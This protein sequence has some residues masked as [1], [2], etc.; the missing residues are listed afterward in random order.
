MTPQIDENLCFLAFW[1][2]LFPEVVFGGSKTWKSVFYVD[3]KLEI[4]VPRGQEIDQKIAPKM[5]TKSS[6]NT[7]KLFVFWDVFRGR[8]LDVFWSKTG[9]PGGARGPQKSEKKWENGPWHF[10]GFEL[11]FGIDFGWIWDGFLD[12]FGRICVISGS[13][14][15]GFWESFLMISGLFGGDARTHSLT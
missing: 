15:G 13:F 2:I 7:K 10:F 9:P 6:K 12:G 11:R 4:K 5:T 14:L 3:E 8:F 1:K